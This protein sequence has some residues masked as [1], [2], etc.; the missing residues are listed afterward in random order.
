[1][2]A[3]AAT[4][5]GVVALGIA[6]ASDA[7]QSERTYTPR[8]AMGQGA[9]TSWRET[10]WDGYRAIAER[11]LPD[12]TITPVQGVREAGVGRT[13]TEVQVRAAGASSGLLSS[14]GASVGTS[15]PV[16]ADGRIPTFVTGLTEEQRDAGDRMLRAG[17]AV[18]FTD[19]KVSGAEATVVVREHRGRRS[20]LLGRAVLPA[21]FVRV[22]AVSATAQAVL[23][24]EAAADL[25]VEAETVGLVV[26]GIDI[27][28][29]QEQ[30]VNEALQAISPDLGFYVER[31]YQNDDETLIL[32]L[33]LGTLGGVLMLGG[34]LTATFLSLSDARPDLATLAAV[35]AAPRSRR[36]VAAAYALVIGLVGA[37]LGA[38]VGFV[39]GV[40][41]T[42][43]L[44]GASWVRE[45]DPSLPTHFLAVPW[46]LVGAVVLALP[47]LTAL[48]VGLATRS[49]LPMVARID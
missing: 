31:G 47:L 7:E 38:A 15:L 19:R 13:F 18:V 49:R 12:A 45:V 41:V 1:V 21:A 28:E 27:T 8:L 36:A 40:A 22:G 3:V 39:P 4:V 10:D 9:V 16:S 23:S 26:D 33:V 30:D 42:Y 46:L 24:A 5:A 25:G 29:A 14:W 44:T 48:V 37:V 17:G 34:T 2:A 35:G 6:N 11:Y 32:L 20:E 43:P